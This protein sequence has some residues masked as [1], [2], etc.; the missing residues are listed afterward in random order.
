[1]SKINSPVYISAPCEIRLPLS[2]T[3]QQFLYIKLSRSPYN[4]CHTLYRLAYALLPMKNSLQFSS[5]FTFPLTPHLCSFKTCFDW[6][7]PWVKT[8]HNQQLCHRSWNV[9]ALENSKECFTHSSYRW[10][11]YESNGSLSSY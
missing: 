4:S 9:R 6:P 1:M 2:I 8:H 10:E 11:K 5:P 3:L 7:V